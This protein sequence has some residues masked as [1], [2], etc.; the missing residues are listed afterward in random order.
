[1]KISTSPLPSLDITTTPI[2]SAITS[3][4]SSEVNSPPSYRRF[5]SPRPPR[6]TLERK[7]SAGILRTD[8]VNRNKSSGSVTVEPTSPAPSVDRLSVTFAMDEKDEE[9]NDKP[10]PD[11]NLTKT[12]HPPKILSETL[13]EEQGKNREEIENVFGPEVLFLS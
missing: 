3:A 6:F 4:I 11:I 8:T 2:I 7:L 9:K 10:E 12:Q 13:A 1:M 5:S